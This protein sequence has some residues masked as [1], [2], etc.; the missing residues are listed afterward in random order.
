MPDDPA[1][2]TSATESPCISHHA[3]YDSSPYA[4]LPN[5]STPNHAAPNY[6]TPGAMTPGTMTPGAMTPNAMTPSTMTP[7]AMTPH[8]M[9]PNAATPLPSSPN[10]GGRHPTIASPGEFPKD[11]LTYAITHSASDAINIAT[12][13]AFNTYIST[14]Q[15]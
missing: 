1:Y 4:D 3:L 9:T 14:T 2:E 6:M 12:N 10:A 8:A 11:A 5:P 13:N 7:N 15:F